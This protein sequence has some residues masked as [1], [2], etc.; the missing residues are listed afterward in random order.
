MSCDLFQ[1]TPLSVVLWCVTCAMTPLSCK[2]QTLLPHKQKVRSGEN[3]YRQESALPDGAIWK[4][5][6][7]SKFCALS[8]IHSAW[9]Q[10]P[11]LG[12]HSRSA[13]V[14]SC[15]C[16]VPDGR[17]SIE[18]SACGLFPHDPG[19]KLVCGHR[20]LILHGRAG[21][22]HD[23]P[24]T[25]PHRE[26]CNSGTAFVQGLQKLQSG[27]SGKAYWRPTR[28]DTR[29]RSARARGSLKSGGQAEKRQSF[30]RQSPARE[31]EGNAPDGAKRKR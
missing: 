1:R 11:H 23:S 4:D 8:A 18:Q 6:H 28:L 14:R 19:L 16:V 27:Q 9:R 30:S 5:N 12:A 3:E 2:R 31:T 26:G 20:P 21:V 17:T 29:L 13:S 15:T 25:R 7:C 22:P 24:T 10:G